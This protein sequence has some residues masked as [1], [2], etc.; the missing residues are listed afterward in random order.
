MASVIRYVILLQ[1][2][3][4]KKYEVSQKPSKKNTELSRSLTIFA[5]P[6]NGDKTKKIT[7]WITSQKPICRRHPINLNNNIKD[8]SQKKDL[9]RSANDTIIYC[10]SL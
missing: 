8:I 5:L 3:T 6:S 1:T 2:K 4:E 10:L 9:P 7:D